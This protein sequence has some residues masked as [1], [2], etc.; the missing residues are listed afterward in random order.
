MG[1][2]EKDVK[3]VREG[4]DFEQKTWQSKGLEQS[5]GGVLEGAQRGW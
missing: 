5:L 2:L 4:V 1:H 3:E